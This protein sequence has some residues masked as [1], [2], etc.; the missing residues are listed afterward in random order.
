[1]LTAICKIRKKSKDERE[2][3][4]SKTFV[5]NFCIILAKSIYMINTKEKKQ[6]TRKENEK[7]LQNNR[8]SSV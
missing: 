7:N 8:L 3:N 5:S 4:R 1:M 6:K 2:R